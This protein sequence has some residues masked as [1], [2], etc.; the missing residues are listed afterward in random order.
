MKKK[1]VAVIQARMGS[2]R[3]PGKVLMPIVGQ[4][5]LWHIIG[6]LKA[7]GSVDDIVLA[8]SVRQQDD[9]IEIFCKKEQVT[10]FRGSEHDV[11]DR[12]Y[13]A[14]A[15]ARADTVIR[16]TGDCP[17]IDPN[18]IGRLIEFKEQNQLDYCGIATGAGVAEDGFCGRYPD[19][20]DAEAFS[21]EALETAWKEAVGDLY[22]EHVT[23]WLWKHPERFKTAAYK[24][25]EKDYSNLRWTLDN[26]ED[27]DLIL[28]IY[29][30]LFPKNPVFGMD[31]VL[32]L[33]NR[34]PHLFKENQQYVGKE[35][36]EK[37][38]N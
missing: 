30:N 38:W 26:I 20:L 11:L 6:R 7:V 21:I 8:T 5:V 24:C 27:Y 33:M 14:A 12:F 32:A 10:C 17:L 29:E 34:K 28:S 37:F 25:R 2:T 13:R 23:P 9:S 35:G 1:T 36:Y 3:L 16:I 19:G 22:R 31:D 4:P 18:L 15:A